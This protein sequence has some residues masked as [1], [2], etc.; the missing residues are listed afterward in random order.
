MKTKHLHGKLHQLQKLLDR[1]GEISDVQ[2]LD[3]N[4]LRKQVS[5]L[6]ADRQQLRAKNKRLISQISLLRR[7]L[8]DK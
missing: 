8:G 5:G 2:R 4:R 1:H 7:K 6:R 3:V